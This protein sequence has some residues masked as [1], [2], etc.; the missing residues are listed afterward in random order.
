MNIDK[1]LNARGMNCPIPLMKTKRALETM[2]SGQVLR[3]YATDSASMKDILEFV[4]GAGHTMLDQ[5]HVGKDYIH[6][7]RRG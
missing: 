4:T 2:D 6:T 1:E 5:E 3:V 7:I